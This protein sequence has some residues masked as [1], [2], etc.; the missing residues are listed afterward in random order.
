MLELLNSKKFLSA[1]I[2]TIL[3]IA[4]H[5]LFADKPDSLE[6]LKFT[7]TGLFVTQILAQGGADLG[8]EKAKQEKEKAIAEKQKAEIEIKLVEL[9]KQPLI[10]NTENNPLENFFVKNP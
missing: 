6:Y 2:G 9:N 10:Q 1:I 3:L 7:I 5:L 8:K 4:V